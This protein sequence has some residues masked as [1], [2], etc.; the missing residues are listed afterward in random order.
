MQGRETNALQ[1]Q[2]AITMMR[3]SRGWR[4]RMDGRLA[5][6]GL[7]Q[8]KWNTLYHLALNDGPVMQRDLASIVGVEGPTMVRLLDGLERQGLIERVPAV[9]DRRGKMIRLTPASESVVAE[10]CRISRQLKAEIFADIPEDDL[11]HCHR[12]LLKVQHKL[13]G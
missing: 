6:L 1:E 10:M 4:T 13:E 8:G 5:G 11:E 3:I 7:T 2:L 9:H 12:V